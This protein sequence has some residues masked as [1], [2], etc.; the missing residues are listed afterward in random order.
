MEKK[1]DDVLLTDYA[2]ARVFDAEEHARTMTDNYNAIISVLADMY[3]TS[4]RDFSCIE[5]FLMSFA[6]EG[7][8]LPVQ[9][10]APTE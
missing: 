10:E 9:G 6:P 5:D 7:Y 1:L 3:Q 2:K 8:Q 4:P